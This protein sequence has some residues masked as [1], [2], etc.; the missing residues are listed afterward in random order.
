MDQHDSARGDGWSSQQSHLYVGP[1]QAVQPRGPQV[2]QFYHN[3]HEFTLF[4]WRRYL[5]LPFPDPL[6]QFWRKRHSFV[7]FSWNNCLPSTKQL[8]FSFR[9]LGMK[10]SPK[11][12]SCLY[13]IEQQELNL[14]ETCL[15]QPTKKPLR[16][17]FPRAKFRYY[18]CV[19]L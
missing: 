6:V 1:L 17:L 10:K 4:K 3:C 15:R 14:R 9:T 11:K 16:R 2:Y 7:H 18:I 5:T 8:P 13:Y 19:K 12:S